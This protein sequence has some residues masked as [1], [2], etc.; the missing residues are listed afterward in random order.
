MAGGG[1]RCSEGI[2]A[3]AIHILQMSGELLISK[4]EESIDD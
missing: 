3:L 4:M 1:G 2:S